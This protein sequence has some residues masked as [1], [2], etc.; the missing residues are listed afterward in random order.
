MSDSFVI[1]STECW[2]SKR[3]ARKELLYKALLKEGGVDYLA[4]IEPMRRWWQEFRG[5]AERKDGSAHIYRWINPIPYERYHAILLMNR[6]FLAARIS[7]VIP[8][9]KD[10]ITGIFYHHYNWLVARHVRG[11]RQWFF[12]WTD[13]WGLYHQSSS[14]ARM[15]DECIAQCDGVIA[16][17][18][19][20]Y[21]RARL[22][23][24]DDRVL[25]LPNATSLEPI[26][27][28]EE[29]PELKNIPHPRICFIEH[30]GPWV[31]VDLIMDIAKCRPD[32]QWC[33]IGSVPPS[34]MEKFKNYKNVHVLGI[35]PYETLPHWMWHMDVLVAPSIYDSPGDVSKI[36]DYLTSGKAIVSSP[37]ETAHRFTGL[38]SI[39]G[40]DSHSWE[41]ALDKS[42]Y[43]NEKDLEAKRQEAA[44][45]NNWFRR[46]QDLL[47]WL[48]VIDKKTV[49]AAGDN[50]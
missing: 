6:L 11:I 27:V 24:G 4:Y 43:D 2:D 16:V 40:N 29:P 30:I 47:R 13:D 10:A 32:Y 25:F 20:L 21:D 48:H 36:Y 23:R 12:D 44:R 38:I 15:Q 5:T 39:A 9:K 42:L 14:V 28:M 18:K 35:Q 7:Q 37:S 26:D 1:I 49:S 8:K 31:D 3:Q 45:A 33:I 50:K 22:I 19:E 46:A 41:I 17:S 34:V